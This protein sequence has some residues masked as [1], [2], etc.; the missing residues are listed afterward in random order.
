MGIATFGICPAINTTCRGTLKESPLTMLQIT[1]LP[2]SIW[3]WI[4][5]QPCISVPAPPNHAS[6]A[7]LS[8]QGSSRRNTHLCPQRQACQYRS[9]CRLWSVPVTQLQPLPAVVQETSCLHRDLGRDTPICVHRDRSTNLSPWS[10]PVT[11][12]HSLPAAVQEQFCPPKAPPSD[13][14]GALPGNFQESNTSV[15]L[16]TGLPSADPAADLEADLCHSGSLIRPETREDPCPLKPLVIGLT[17][18][19]PTVDPAA[20]TLSSPNTAQ[21]CSQRQSH[22]SRNLTW[23]GVYLL[24]PVCK[25]LWK[26]YLP[27]ECSAPNAKLQKS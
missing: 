24:K 15:H 6:K 3:L 14:A 8:A 7:V 10:G 2:T 27:I 25:Y 21:L 17:N 20:S 4:L 11:W 5:K 1:G 23:E 18:M 12:L 16:V 9:N 19:D 26:R 22:Q 13:S